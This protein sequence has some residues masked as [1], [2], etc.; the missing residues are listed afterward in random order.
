MYGLVL[1]GG[2]AKG[3]YH[4]GALKALQELEIKIDAVAG[5]SIGAMNGAMFVQGKLDAAYDYWYNIS[6]AKV[7]DIEDKYLSQLLNLSINQNNLSYF[8]N[9][10]KE[11]LQNRGLDNSF[12]QELLK[13]NIDEA[14]L[15][16][17]EI[18]FA[19]LTLSLSD[20]KPLEL[21]IEDIPPGKVVDYILASSYL[22]AFKLQRIDG[23]ILIDGGFYEN[24]PVKTLLAKGYKKIIAVRTY[25][26]GRED[27][28]KEPEEDIIYINPS[29]K[30]G[31]MLNFE[32]ENARENIKMG[33]FDTMRYFKNLA[34]R[35]YYLKIREGEKY[36][37]NYLLGLDSQSIEK[38]LK[39]LSLTEK[40]QRR[41]LFEN[42]IPKLLDLLEL[43]YQAD[44]SAI[45]VSLLEK[46]AADL[47]IDRYK[48]YS[49][50]ELL[51]LVK[52]NYH[53]KEAN[54]TERLPAF[55]K[56][57]TLLPRQ[58]KEDLILDIAEQLFIKNKKRG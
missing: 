17:S 58:L 13:D 16:N 48:I 26:L 7:L 1:E 51:K 31:R 9:K 47:E 49:F 52:A 8:I 18:D 22:P 45:I 39:Q 15:R 42:F 5:T 30:L 44:Y 10:I 37:I 33:Y 25:A 56:T 43:D 23:K 4:I 41:S 20:L 38:I 40:P 28:I 53:Q 27:N 36:F 11:V 29:Q 12:L 54:F 21:F 50:E 32:R 14:S 2:G 35:E 24:L 19:L 3:A 55:I 46:I 34:G 57:S 6:T